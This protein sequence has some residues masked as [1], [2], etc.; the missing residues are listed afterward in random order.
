M[1]APPPGA[2]A[3]KRNMNTKLQAAGQILLIPLQYVKENPL[4]SRIYYNDAHTLALMRSI[5]QSGIVEPLTV[6]RGAGGKYVIISG[7]RV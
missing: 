2:A 4:R 7:E 5:A 1:F 3:R 6:C